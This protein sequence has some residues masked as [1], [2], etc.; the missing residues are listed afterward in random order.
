MNKRIKS[1]DSSKIVLNQLRLLRKKNISLLTKIKQFPKAERKSRKQEQL[2]MKKA[3][4]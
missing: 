1:K 2:L 3:I 4:W